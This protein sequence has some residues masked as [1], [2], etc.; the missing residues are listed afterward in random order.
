MDRLGRG[1]RAEHLPRSLE[2]EPKGGQEQQA[3][4]RGAQGSET[5]RAVCPWGH[6]RDGSWFDQVRRPLSRAE[7]RDLTFRPEQG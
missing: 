4:D 2:A 6:E 3:E 5:P 7:R 1:P